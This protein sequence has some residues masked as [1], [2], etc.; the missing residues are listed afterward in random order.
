MAAFGRSGLFVVCIALLSML[1]PKNARH[2]SMLEGVP[3]G[4]DTC[5]WH[6]SYAI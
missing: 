2:D 6:L 5:N 3:S 4:K 1:L